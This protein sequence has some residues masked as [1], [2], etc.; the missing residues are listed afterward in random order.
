MTNANCTFLVAI[1]SIAVSS[2][3]PD[4]EK[5]NAV[6]DRCIT[7]AADRSLDEA[8]AIEFARAE[9]DRRQGRMVYTK[10]VASMDPAVNAWAV[11]AVVE[12]TVPGGHVLVSISLDGKVR[13][14]SI[15]R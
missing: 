13:D 14:Y 15:G 6:G 8:C 1:A 12:P 10:F 11:M 4:G 9:I 5:Q 2:C 7:L 3:A